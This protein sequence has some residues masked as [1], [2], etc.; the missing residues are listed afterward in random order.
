M[1]NST[2]VLDLRLKRRGWLAGTVAFILLALLQ[3]VGRAAPELD[4]LR[5]LDNLGADTLRRH[6]AQPY[7]APVEVVVLD[8]VSLRAAEDQAGMAFPWPRTAYADAV[9]FLHRAGARAV[10]FDFLFTSASVDPSEDRALAAAARRQ[11]H[12]VLGMQFTE[13]QQ[14]Q[15]LRDFLAQAPLYRHAGALGPLEASRSVD[16]PRPPLW[17]AVS[18]VGDTHFEQ[19]S[20]GLGRRYRLATALSASA[21][22]LVAYPSLALATAD[23]LGLTLPAWAPA[24]RQ[25]RFS[26]LFRQPKGDAGSVRLFDLAV[27]WSKLQAGEKPLVDPA[28]FQG[29]VVF[30]G[31]S[32]A[33]L[34]DLKSCPLDKALP[35]VE[36]QAMA[37]DDLYSGQRLQ[38]LRA[39]P[40]YWVALLLLCLFLATVSFRLRGPL[41]LLPTLAFLA[42]NGALAAWLYGR[43]NLL[44]P[45][46]LPS[47]AAVLAFSHGAVENFVEERRSRQRVTDVFGQFLSPGVLSTL[48]GR[49]GALEMGGETRTLT[50]FFSDLQGFTNFSEKLKPHELVLI[51]NEYLTEMGEVIAGDFDGTVDKYIGDAIMAFWNAPTDQP[52]HAWRGCAAAW[53]CQMRLAQIQASLAAKGLDAGAEGLVMRIGL[54]TGPAVAGLMGSQRKLNYTVMGDTV[55][56]AS[57]LEGANK[58]YGSRIL[59]SQATKDAAGPR[60]LTRPLDYIKV[61]GKAEATAVFQVIGLDGEPGRLYDEAYGA[62]WSAALQ[63]YKEGR[64]TEALARFLACGARQPGDGAVA[65]FA[66]RCRH[67]SDEPPSAWDGVY[68]MKTK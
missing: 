14:P 25:G 7:Q 13:A 44:L 48:K 34:D 64:F 15:A 40:L 51:L 47:A 39:G 57:R 6:L 29:K 37:F 68:T 63:A 43:F 9:D 46:G 10:V 24:L 52:D 66:E 35:G 36:L 8:D 42:L 31:S 20:D 12:V 56:T 45:L 60:V 23:S 30:I 61:K 26:L 67:Y 32:A 38:V 49:Q 17:G 5:R 58:P 18:A 41:A 19:D 62:A 28:R 59:I 53:A 3:W 2:S 65:L 27:S 55:N 54:N 21:G 11:G 33:G 16:A 50:V 4:L 1:P 22:S